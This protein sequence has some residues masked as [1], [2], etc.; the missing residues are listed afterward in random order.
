MSALRLNGTATAHNLSDLAA[1]DDNRRVID[2]RATGP[3]NQANILQNI[4]ACGRAGLS[5]DGGQR[6][7]Y[8]DRER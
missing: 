3:V 5:E 4:T 2:R 8:E 1:S 6:S 7:K